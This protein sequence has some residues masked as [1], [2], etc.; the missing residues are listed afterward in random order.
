MRVLE[1]GP[2]TN[3]RG[4]LFWP[5]AEQVTVDIDPNVKATFTADA[6]NLPAELRQGDFDI[7][8]AAHVLEHIPYMISSQVVAS[9]AEC[10]KPG[11]AMHVIVP[12][13]E[14]AAKQVMKEEVN[15]AWVPHV[16]GGLASP[17]DVHV[18]QF[19]MRRLRAVMETAGLRV[20]AAQ[21]GLYS[22]S[23]NGKGYDCEEHYVKAVKP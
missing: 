17:N 9:W 6:R 19:T 16:C 5:D 1:I 3:P 12:S 10:L 11:G 23:I 18:A 2:R 13:F 20:V 4:P 22:I 14:W 15:P 8:M 7:V 21:R